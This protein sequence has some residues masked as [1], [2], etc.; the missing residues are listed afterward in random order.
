[1][2]KTLKTLYALRVREDDNSP[3]GDPKV[4]TRKRFRDEH[5]T[6]LRG[7]FGMRTHSF[8]RT[9]EEEEYEEIRQVGE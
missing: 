8:E 4:F 7:L 9:A 1:M 6:L 2:K 3:W 5:A